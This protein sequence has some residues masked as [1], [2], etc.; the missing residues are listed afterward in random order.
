MKIGIFLR[1]YE[2]NIAY[3]RIKADFYTE[4]TSILKNRGK[5]IIGKAG[6]GFPN[7]KI[8][9]LN[10]YI[11]TNEFLILFLYNAKQKK[12]YKAK[13]INVSNDLPSD[14]SLYPSY[15]TE[16]SAIKLSFTSIELIEVDLITLEMLRL[17]TNKRNIVDVIK[18]CRTSCMIIEYEQEP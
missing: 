14:S 16:L 1:L 4:H 13:V 5:V 12:L 2:I 6:A 8:E 11:K 17:A 15:Y 10:N 18:S 7:S 9:L 3:G